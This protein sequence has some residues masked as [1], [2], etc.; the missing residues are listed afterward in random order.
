MASEKSMWEALRPLMKGLDPMRVENLVG[1]GTPDVNYTRGWI[2]LKYIGGWPVRDPDAIVKVDHF[3]PQ[4]RVWIMRRALAGGR[5][6]V[7]LKVGEEWLLF[8]GGW[9]ARCL[10]RVGKEHLCRNALAHWT[11]KPTKEDL[12]KWL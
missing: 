5:V 4:Q 11:Q 2:E 1:I 8:N 9:A 3:T 6:F 12:Q 7:F 10:G